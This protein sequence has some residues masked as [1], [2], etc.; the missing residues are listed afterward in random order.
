MMS[1][2]SSISL[3]GRES[4]PAFP[5]PVKANLSNDMSNDYNAYFQ[6]QKNVPPPQPPVGSR[7]P[8]KSWYDSSTYLSSDESYKKHKEEEIVAAS[9]SADSSGMLFVLFEQG[10]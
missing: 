10:Y 4:F 2:D 3:I 6:H 1:G 7:V 9:K 8:S 5:V